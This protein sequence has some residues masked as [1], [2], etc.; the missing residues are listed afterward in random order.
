MPYTRVWST[1]RPDGATVAANTLDSE[2]QFV[3]KDLEERIAGIFGLNTA[4]FAA[5]PIV[6][7][8]LTLSGQLEAATGNYTG[9]LVAVGAGTNVTPGYVANST[10]LGNPYIDLRQNGVSRALLQYSNNNARL[11]ITTATVY[12]SGII[13][14]AGRISST[15]ANNNFPTI[16]APTLI[17]IANDASHIIA[18]DKTHAYVMI[19]NNA[20]NESALVEVNSVAGT[21]I[22]RQSG[23]EYGTVFGTAGKTNLFFTGSSI[24]VQ[25]KIGGARNYY[26]LVFAV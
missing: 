8:S 25:N 17:P 23:A 2:I 10:A 24:Y 14:P 16:E 1:T 5:D 26:I 19:R 3:R 22:I 15:A 6:P 11:E 4:Q 7:I 13:A 18:T 21:F 9:A 20:S 12:F